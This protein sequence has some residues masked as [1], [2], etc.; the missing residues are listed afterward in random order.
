MCSTLVISRW[1]S[2]EFRET[3]R[4]TGNRGF[5]HELT[6]TLEVAAKG[7]PTQRFCF[8]LENPCQISDAD[9]RGTEG[10]L[11]LTPASTF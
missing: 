9:K 4:S 3:H 6:G 8:C 2:D 1:L 5:E 7:M 11:V 10:E